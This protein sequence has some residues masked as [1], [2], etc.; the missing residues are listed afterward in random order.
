MKQF[1]KD[2]IKQL[3][4]KYRTI[5]AWGYFGLNIL[6]TIPIIGLIALIIC[7]CSSKNI[8]RRSYARSFFCMLIFILIVGGIIALLSFTVLKDTLAPI[9]E[10][11]MQMIQGGAG[12]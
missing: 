4:S 3:P 9:W 8:N 10:Q 12:E 2:E 1:E 11:I 5:G 7:A 6:F